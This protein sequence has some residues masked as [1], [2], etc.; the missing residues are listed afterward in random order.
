MDICIA[1]SDTHV[2]HIKSNLKKNTIPYI[3][4]MAQ[5]FSIFPDKSFTANIK[6]E[7]LIDIDVKW[8]MLGSDRITEKND[9]IGVKTF[10]AL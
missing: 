3:H 10:L 9:E 8:V 7:Y 4:E 6:I 2:T 5:N 1:C